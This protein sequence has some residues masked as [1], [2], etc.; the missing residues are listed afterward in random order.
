[1]A[2]DIVPTSL[3]ASLEGRQLPVQG[4]A[5]NRDVVVV[6]VGVP[7]FPRPA[8]TIEPWR[9]RPA[10][11]LPTAR[12]HRRIDWRL[13][14]IA[15]VLG[16]A[17]WAISAIGPAQDE[18]FSL[19]IPLPPAYRADAAIQPPV[20]GVTPPGG[21][22]PVPEMAAGLPPGEPRAEATGSA[23]LAID[24]MPEVES[25]M[26]KAMR[27][28]V[29]EPWAAMGLKGFALAGPI[30]IEDNNAC[31]ILAVWAEADGSAGKPISSLR[32]LEE[33]GRW[34]SPPDGAAARFAAA[35]GA[36]GAISP[37]PATGPRESPVSGRESPPSATSSAPPDS[38]DGG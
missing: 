25:A 4:K 14:L 15:P 11:A 17:A 16:L 32:C 37:A 6:V 12:R 21:A 9:G 33:S 38:P 28:G 20:A 10:Y 13:L 18:G 27:S 22:A 1:L 31:R 34:V 36:A 26:R 29:A 3:L 2:N 30:Q 19:R 5:E 35:S 24:R 8:R 7:V 23:L